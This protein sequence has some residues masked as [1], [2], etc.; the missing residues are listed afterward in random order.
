LRVEAT[1]VGIVI[2]ALFVLWQE[3]KRAR[4]LDPE[5]EAREGEYGWRL[6][7]TLVGA[8]AMLVVG[9]ILVALNV[10]GGGWLAVAA[11]VVVVGVVY[12]GP[13]LAPRRR[14]NDAK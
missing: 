6:L 14:H 10:R 4:E 9:L 11:L 13:W 3:R 12:V 7:M 5:F 2:A 1:V 8:V